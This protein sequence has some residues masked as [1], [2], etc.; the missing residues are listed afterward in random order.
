MH[1]PVDVHR[2]Q[3]LRRLLPHHGDLVH[4]RVEAVAALALHPQKV[5]ATSKVPFLAVVAAYVHDLG[6]LG[7]EGLHLDVPGDGRPRGRHAFSTLSSLL[8]DGAARVVVGELLEAVPVDTVPT[9]HLVA[10]AAAA[11]QVLLADGAVRHVFADLAVVFGEG[12]VVDAHP[13]VKAVAEVLAAADAAEAAVLTMIGLFPGV[14]PEVA[15]VAVVF[16]ELDVAVYAFVS[17]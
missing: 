12:V 9:G 10:G 5:P 16:A 15:G 1:P 13:A 14:H 7:G 3:E 17:G 2:L 8:A 4:A 11:E 6:P